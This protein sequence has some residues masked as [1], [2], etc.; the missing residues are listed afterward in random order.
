[1]QQLSIGAG[2]IA[3]TVMVHATFMAAM[4]S[5][6]RRHPPRLHTPFRQAFTIATVVI[7]FFLAIAVQ[8]W[9][10]ALLFILLGAFEALEPA[11][12]FTTVTYTTLGYGDVV[13][14]EDWRLLSAFA[15]A[16]GTIMIGWTT[17]LVFLAVERV[18]KLRRASSNR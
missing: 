16:N 17:A 5:W 13:L 18:Y 12:Y 3:L 8:A 10:W 11:L 6:F 1:L 7:W 4:A 9:A 14:G 15:A 2:M